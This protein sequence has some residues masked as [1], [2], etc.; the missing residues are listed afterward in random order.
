MPFFHKK[1]K[2]A[3]DPIFE[4]LIGVIL[5][6]IIAILIFIVAKDLSGIFFSAKDYESTIKSFELLGKRIDSLVEDKNYVNSNMLYFLDPEYVMVGYNYKDPSVQMQTCQKSGTYLFKESESL[7]ESRRK[8]G[9][10]CEKAC[11]CIYKNT[12]ANDFDKDLQLPLQCKDF[13]RNVVFL[14][15]SEQS[16]IFCSIESGWHPSAYP[17]YYEAG[18]GY[19][20]LILYGFNVKEIYLDKYESPDGNIFIFLAEYKNKPDEPIYQ[21]KI[22]ME[23]NYEKSLKSSNQK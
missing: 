20:F 10:L 18:Q 14:A 15:P 12:P 9:S 19:K 23:Q 11:L 8:I 2:G 16:D 21:R 6:A 3:L 5:F 1:K 4:E 13:D 17:D 22:F 7:V